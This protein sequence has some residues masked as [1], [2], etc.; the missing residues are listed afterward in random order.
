[1]SD[2]LY[3]CL[4]GCPHGAPSI[5]TLVAEFMHSG[6]L[7]AMLQF[8]QENKLR[9]LGVA[10][11]QV[12]PLVAVM[13]DLGFAK[14]RFDSTI[15]PGGKL[16]L[17]LSPVST[18]LAIVASDERNTKERRA[19]AQRAFRFLG[20]KYAIALG[21]SAD[22]GIVWE[23]LLRLFDV[24]DHDIAASSEQVE[25]H[26]KLLQA[27]FMKGGVFDPRSWSSTWG[28][29]TGELKLAPVVAHCVGEAGVTGCFITEHVGRQ[30]AR[31]CEFNVAGKPIVLWGPLAADT[32]RELG[33]RTQNAA[34][35]GIARLTA[36]LLG[37]AGLRHHFRCLHIPLIQKVFGQQPGQSDPSEQRELR[38][39]FRE[40]WQMLKLP[41]QTLDAATD[42]Y[43]T[44]ARMFATGTLPRGKL[45]GMTSKK[46]W[47]LCLH[48]TWLK[49]ICI[50]NGRPYFFQ[51]VFP[52]VRL[53][54]AILDGTVMVERDHALLRTILEQTQGQ[55]SLSFLEDVLTVRCSKIQ[56]Q[57]MV[58]ADGACRG[59]LGDVGLACAKCWR[60]VFGARLGIGR[61]LTSADPINA[62]SRRL[63]SFK[64]IKK[65]VLKAAGLVA[66]SIRARPR[67]A[68]GK[69]INMGH[70]GHASGG[71]QLGVPSNKYWNKRFFN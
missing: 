9:P 66:L 56:L 27:L 43:T 8:A 50:D 33:E 5:L 39:A 16:A 55:A 6:K 30:V 29:A 53:Y 44:L 32:K 1:M 17:M 42:E 64:D 46:V 13:K 51:H 41:F 22:W 40:L 61:K 10:D 4:W 28:A 3:F 26:I 67:S 68:N 24:D 49:K 48:A 21:I 15:D 20:T 69:Y 37:K 47:S 11:A 35:V 59:E 70:T 71:L 63:Q 7:K 31:R 57:D 23:V 34:K 18:V 58:P 2:L 12:S 60:E 25:A 45:Y 52:V 36:D 65:G 54:N 14:Q 19:N 62:S 38:R